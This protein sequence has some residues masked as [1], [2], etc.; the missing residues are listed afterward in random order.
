MKNK[1]PINITF[2]NKYEHKA[3]QQFLFDNGCKWCYGAGSELY[4]GGIM[5]LPDM[6]KI[7]VNTDKVMGHT[8]GHLSNPTFTIADLDTIKE[9]LEY[10]PITI[11]LNS[12]Y[13]AEIDKDTQT[14][15]VGCQSFTFDKIRELAS[16][17][18]E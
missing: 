12:G 8:S 1:L 4:D 5:S 10:K 7:M 9:I 16:K 18:G 6:Y 2:K 11:Q 14:V 15:K 13:T 17:I 3:I